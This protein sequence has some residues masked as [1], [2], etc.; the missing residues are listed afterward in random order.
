VVGA[1]GGTDDTREG[2]ATAEW[3]AW[4]GPL[5]LI[6]TGAAMVW[7][8]WG[9]WPDPLVDFGREL[10]VPW[11]LAQGGRLFTDIAWF[12]GPLSQLERPTVSVHQSSNRSFRPHRD[13]AFPD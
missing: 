5:L 1:T 11:R 8:T 10:Y 13:G 9:A 2:A 3:H 4:V 7:W 6:G 12:S